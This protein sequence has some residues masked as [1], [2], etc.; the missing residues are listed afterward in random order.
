M[1][2]RPPP[3][4]SSP[5]PARPPTTGSTG[6]DGGVDIAFAEPV[7][8]AGSVEGAD[9]AFSRRRHRPRGCS[10]GTNPLP[11][12]CSATFGRSTRTS[13][14][15]PPACRNA[16]AAGLAA[17]ATTS[18]P[19][20]GPRAY[21][22]VVARR[23][24]LAARGGAPGGSPPGAPL[25]PQSP[26]KRLGEARTHRDRLMSH[27]RWVLSQVHCCARQHGRRSPQ[28]CAHADDDQ[29]RRGPGHGLPL[30][31]PRV[32]TSTSTAPPG[33]GVTRSHYAL[34]PRIAPLGHRRFMR[35]ESSGPGPTGRSSAGAICEL[36][37]YG[38]GAARRAGPGVG[39]NR[40]SGPGAA[41][42]SRPLLQGP[43]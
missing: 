9:R 18:E 19:R 31:R 38:E 1:V 40:R 20:C 28:P 3:W 27:R 37:R 13:T 29:R 14:T 35:R 17:R 7:G 15:V 26:Q 6:E 43:G 12:G 39:W 11:G 2:G 16:A 41:A 8:R 10:S 30:G 21:E 24:P 22:A 33:T 32:L 36:H 25:T 4:A 34:P 5:P 42:W 23:V